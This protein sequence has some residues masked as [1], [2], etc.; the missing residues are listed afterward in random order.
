MP[1]AFQVN[2]QVK[3]S[4]TEQSHRLNDAACQ[5][6]MKQGVPSSE[7]VTLLAYGGHG[8]N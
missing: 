6:V 5:S 3:E 2:P 1:L 4:F 8:M 7:S